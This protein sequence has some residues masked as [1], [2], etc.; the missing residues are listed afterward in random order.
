MTKEEQCNLLEKMVMD[1][2]HPAETA[3]KFDD[4]DKNLYIRLHY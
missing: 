4:D 2:Y 3:C 1:Q